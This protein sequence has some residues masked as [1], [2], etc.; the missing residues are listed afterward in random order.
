MGLGAG[1]KFI[2][3][4]K[5][6]DA[7]KGE[8]AKDRDKDYDKPRSKL[9]KDD[10][11]D[12]PHEASGWTAKID[13]WLCHGARQ[14]SP[15]PS[16]ISV[17]KRLSAQGKPKERKG[18]YQLLIKGLLFSVLRNRRFSFPFHS[19]RANDGLVPGNLHPS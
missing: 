6:K 17:P 2:D 15:T 14:A 1:F 18:P 11:K 12:P 8:R 19:F 3:R 9:H 16:D 13:E 10:A 7:E 5:D 4:E